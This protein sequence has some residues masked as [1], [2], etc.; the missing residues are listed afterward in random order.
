[1]IAITYLTIISHPEATICSFFPCVFILHVDSLWQRHSL[2]QSLASILS[3]AIFWFATCHFYEASESCNVCHLFGVLSSGSLI[4][5]A[6]KGQGWGGREGGLR[7][8]DKEA[9]P[10]CRHPSACPYL[11][12]EEEGPRG[13]PGRR[14]MQAGSSCGGRGHGCL[15]PPVPL[16]SCLPPCSSCSEVL[17]NL[18]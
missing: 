11:P 10:V 17:P 13:G 18:L 3:L 2:Y 5:T 12:A 9:R 7:E 14:V 1:M 15:L 16:P 6:H 8:E 4:G